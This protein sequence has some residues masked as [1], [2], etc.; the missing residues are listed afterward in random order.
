MM[1]LAPRGKQLVYGHACGS[2]RAGVAQG[3][4]AARVDDKEAPCLL[5]QELVLAEWVL[6]AEA[7][8]SSSP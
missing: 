1:S 6:W 3:L 4:W 2:S 7:C 8:P 5:A